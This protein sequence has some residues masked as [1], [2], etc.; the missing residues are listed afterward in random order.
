MQPSMAASFSGFMAPF[1]NKLQQSVPFRFLAEKVLGIDK[2]RVLPAYARE[3][4]TEWYGKNYTPLEGKTKV[5][6]FADTYIN[7]HEPHIG[8][9]AID[10]LNT[11][12]YDVVLASVG[13][14]Q[15]PLIS[16]G[17]LTKAKEQGT[18][19]AEALMPY[20]QQG[21]HVLVCEPSCTSALTD[22]LPDLIDDQEAARMLQE[23]VLA[24]DVFLGKEMQAGR[25]QGRFHA[26]ADNI[27][28][29]GHCHQKAGTGTREMKSVYDTIDGLTATVP[30]SGCCG[31]AGAFG[32]EKEHYDLSM[33]IANLELAPA[34]RKASEGTLV[35][36]N[37]FSCRHQIQDACHQKAVHWVES[38]TFTPA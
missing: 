29:H 9:A 24:I 6:L 4:L 32:Y 17:F 15:R 33:D 28:L 21:M 1:V 10:L 12:G 36:A 18:K 37:G 30:D 19:V 2:R 11:C 27:L 26:M 3:S 22:D 31:M 23:K 14:C 8:K 38:I 5:A 20:I 25:L 35:V 16:N 34:I 13:C 7:Y